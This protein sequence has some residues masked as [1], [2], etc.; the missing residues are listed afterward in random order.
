MSK[1]SGDPYAEEFIRFLSMGADP[2]T[3]RKTSYDSIKSK[4]YFPTPGTPAAKYENIRRAL[5]EWGFLSARKPI[6]P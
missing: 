4:G 2:D 1:L 3:F 6:A 5:K